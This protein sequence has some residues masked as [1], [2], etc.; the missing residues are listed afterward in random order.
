MVILSVEIADTHRVSAEYMHVSN[1]RHILH[2]CVKE[3]VR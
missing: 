1:S 3:N 2:F